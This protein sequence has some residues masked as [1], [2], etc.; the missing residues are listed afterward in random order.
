MLAGVGAFTILVAL[1]LLVYT[2]FSSLVATRALVDHTHAVIAS[3]DS[4]LI[5]VEDAESRQR[6][7]VITGSKAFLGEDGLLRSD[8]ADPI[9][10]LSHLISDNPAQV[11]SLDSLNRLVSNKLQLMKAIIAA[12]EVSGPEAAANM[13]RSGR[14]KILMDSIQA[15]VQTMK[16][17]ELKLLAERRER[18][19]QSLRRTVVAGVAGVLSAVLLALIAG[20]LFRRVLIA[21]ARGR[22]S[23][24][25]AETLLNATTEGIY[26]LDRNG[27]IRFVN[28]ATGSILGYTAEEMIG[29]RAH[30]LLHHTGPDGTPY[31]A[32]ECPMYGVLHSGGQGVFDNEIVWRKDNTSIPVEYSVSQMVDSRGRPGA[33][34]SFRDITDRQIAEAALRKGKESAESANRAKSDFLARMSHELRTPLN[35]VIGFS[36]VLLRNKSGNL[37][38]QDVSY[39]DRI[40]KNGVKLLSL[41][42]DILDLSKIEAGRMEVENGPVDLDA[43]IREVVA[44]FETQV[45]EKSIALIAVIPHKVAEVQSD[46][47]KIQ[48]I[49]VNLIGNAIKFTDNGA[50]RVTLTTDPLTNAPVALSIS[51]TGIGIPADRMNAVF[52]V[53]EQAEKSTT[54]R[55][56][57]TGLGLPIC[58]SLCALLGYELKVSSV[59]GTGSTFVIDLRPT[60]K[61]SPGVTEFLPSPEAEAAGAEAVLRG[62]LVLIIDDDPDARTLIAHQVASL[63]GR[64]AGASHGKDA[65]RVAREISP[66]LITLDLLMPD[67]D[68]WDVIKALKADPVLCEI[69]VVIVSMV[70]DE[71]GKGLVGA[72]SVLPKPLDRDSLAQALKK[73]LGVGRV[74]VVEDNPD[75]Q[76]LLASYLYEA[77]A[78]EVRVVSGAA[79]AITSLKEFGPDLVLLDLVVPQGGGE[80]FIDALVGLALPSPPKVIVVTSKELSSE[81]VRKLQVATLSIVSKGHDLE[82]KLKAQLRR[83]ATDRGRV[84][85]SGTGPRTDQA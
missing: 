62:K 45:A 81:E 41:I 49:L 57:G 29:Q 13:I 43:L 31:P 16:S 75:L 3:L 46:G 66:D 63:G 76:Y 1:G 59:E 4:L 37:R 8:L 64:S 36:N 55:Y 50:V 26:G 60:Q 30:S 53:F 72:L 23:A 7:F 12:R 83:F 9:N 39:L 73:G 18:E 10:S 82:D 79:D 42:N 21:L 11:K 85:V 33:V 27:A 68:G 5:G 78:A 74:L 6:G 19:N 38:E 84:G 15:S 51:D 14:G 44:Q 48:Q 20:V 34:V 35:S 22:R 80:S 70:A 69:P 65:I 52:E 77:G 32:A 28:R 24:L 40:Q 56:G 61:L 71:R 54:R 25:Y 58:R 67:M 2:S 47:G 17:R